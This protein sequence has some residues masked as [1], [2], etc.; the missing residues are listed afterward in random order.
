M[1]RRRP[2][3]QQVYLDSLRAMENDVLW[4][5]F[6]EDSEPDDYDGGYT[7]RG[8]WYRDTV[9]SEVEKRLEDCGFLKIHTTGK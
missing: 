9:H 6:L 1:K 4:I 3:W 7:N 8:Q 5:R 2:K